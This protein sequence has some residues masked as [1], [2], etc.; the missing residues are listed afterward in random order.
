M[1]IKLDENMPARLAVILSGLGH[2][3]T[4]VPKEALGG[5]DDTSIWQ[6]AQ[7]EGRFLITQDLDF[8]DIRRFRPGTH[9]GLLLVRLKKP[10]RRALTRAVR[11]VFEAENV[12]TW[13]G[14]FAVL[15]EHKLRLRCPSP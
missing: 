14:C 4:T 7:D 13:P 3:A 8:S 11:A 12:S 9:C 10:G 6:A 1:K 2:D 15:T 5:R